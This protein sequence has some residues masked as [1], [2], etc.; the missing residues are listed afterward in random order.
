MKVKNPNYKTAEQRWIEA[1]RAAID[2]FVAN[3]PDD[4]EFVDFDELRE[5]FAALGTDF[6]DGKLQ[7]ILG[8]LGY[9]VVGD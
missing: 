4:K 1:N 9:E 7:Q 8:D 5:E 2:N 6:T 3:L